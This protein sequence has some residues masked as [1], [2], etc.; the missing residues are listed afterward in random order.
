MKNNTLPE[1]E[2][3]HTVISI[4]SVVTLPPVLTVVLYILELITGTTLKVSLDLNL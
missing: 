4:I 1:H 2:K 3:G